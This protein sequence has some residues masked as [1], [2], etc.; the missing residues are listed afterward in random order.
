MCRRYSS[1]AFHEIF[2]VDINSKGT[3]GHS[4]KLKKARCT[5]DLARA[6]F[7][8]KVINRWNDLDRSAM[9]APS[10]SAFK[11]SL[12]QVRSNRMGFLVD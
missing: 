7:S 2:A 11:N 12:E 5:S 3:S 1:V 6:F 10:I 8:N 4:C 9:D